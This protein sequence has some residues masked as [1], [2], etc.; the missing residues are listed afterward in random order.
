MLKL[1]RRALAPLLLAIAGFAGAAPVQLDQLSA[2]SRP[3]FFS[4]TPVVPKSA[5]A[6]HTKSQAKPVRFNAAQMLK[7]GTLDELDVNLPGLGKHEAVFRH[8]TDHGGGIASWV[9]YL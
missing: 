7:L 2:Q 1:I 8:A 3:Q 5:N 4:S 6:P 9:G